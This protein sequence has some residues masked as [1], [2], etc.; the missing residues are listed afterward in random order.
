MIRRS[1]FNQKIFSSF[2]VMSLIISSKKL[3]YFDVT[4]IMRLLTL[5]ILSCFV[6]GGRGFQSNAVLKRFGPRGRLPWVVGGA[7]QHQSASSILTRR[8]LA[9][10]SDAESSAGGEWTKKRLHNTNWFRSASILL[11]LGVTTQ[12]FQTIVQVPNQVL[13]T[14][15]LLSFAFIWYMV[16]HCL[17]HYIC[18]R[19]YH[20]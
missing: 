16:W 14:L 18:S 7:K 11:V 19:A 2:A 9:E 17:L 3:R 15:H 8:P 13:A 12:G 5:T 1:G 20:V 4:M 6:S 10:S